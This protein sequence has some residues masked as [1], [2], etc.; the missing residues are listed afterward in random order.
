MSLAGRTVVI[1][2]SASGIGR[3]LALGFRADGAHVIGAD[4]NEAGLAAIAGERLEVKRTDVSV[5]ADVDALIAFALERTGRVDVLFNNAGIGSGELIER[6]PPDYFENFIRI[7]LFGCVYG[8][9]A[10]IPVMRAQGAGRIINTLSRHA[11]TGQRGSSAY[12]AAKA[13][14]WQVTLTAANELRGTDILVNGM[15]PGPTQSGMMKGEQYQ[16]PEAVYPH[17]K[18]L[19]EL[20]TGGPSGKVFWNSEVY[21][22]FAPSNE[23][24]AVAEQRAKA[25]D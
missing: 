23:I 7:H 25:R 4:I 17:A 6:M 13:A 16:K 3:A 9:Q 10:A 8:L 20:P 15:I 14:M 11:E 19:A 1:T 5:K 22:M 2:G 21:P 18:F 24:Q 12:G